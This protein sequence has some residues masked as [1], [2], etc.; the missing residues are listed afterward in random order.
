[1][2]RDGALETVAAAL[3]RGTRYL[4]RRGVASAERN[5]RF[6][7]AEAL[8]IDFTGLVGRMTAALDRGPAREYGRLLCERGGRRPL[9]HI[10]GTW[11]FWGLELD[12]G[13]QALIPRPETE[14]LV[15]VTLAAMP[16]EARFVAD[17]GTGTGAIACALAVERPALTLYAIDLERG[18]LELA[19]S[20]VARHGL[21]GRIHL[22]LGD[23]FEP[24]S[25]EVET[26]SLDAIVSNPPYVAEADLA[27][28]EP[29][30][31]E[32]DPHSALVSGPT[33][34]EVIERLV[35]GASQWL[36]PGGL[37]A[38]E[39]GAGQVAAALSAVRAT[40]AYEAE[41]SWPDL[42]GIARVISAHRRPEPDRG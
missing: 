28:L 42:S 37:L 10:L 33:G 24:L 15:E 1:V 3:A 11:E 20:N 41:R 35:A 30:V 16:R 32:H 19:R 25:G 7:L 38:F 8:S 17:I 40:D 14:T 6:L 34:L 21:A 9:Q 27:D 39:I 4:E 12:V 31:R 13:P 22:L 5:A 29:E 36:R 23:L 26:G 2:A 18:A